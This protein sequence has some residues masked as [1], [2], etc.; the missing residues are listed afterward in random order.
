MAVENRAKPYTAMAIPMAEAGTPT[1]GRKSANDGTIA[2]KPSWF[3]ATSTHIQ[4]KHSSL[5]RHGEC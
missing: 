2:P 1:I 3:T 5:E 4:R